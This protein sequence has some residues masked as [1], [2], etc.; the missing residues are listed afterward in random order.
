[1]IN[2]WVSIKTILAEISDTLPETFWN[3]DQII[4]WASK[5]LRAMRLVETY[6]MVPHF[7]TI[8][9]YKAK[10]PK[11]YVQMEQVALRKGCPTNLVSYDFDCLKEIN[12]ESDVQ[13][14]FKANNLINSNYYR[15][16]WVPMR[17]NRSGHFIMRHVSSEYREWT[18]RHYNGEHC[19]ECE[20]SWSID[21]HGCLISDL[22]EGVI[23]MIHYRWPLD[24]DGYFKIPDHETIREAIRAY[25]MK[26]H[27]ET[28]WNLKEEGSGERMQYYANKWSIARK[29]ANGAVKAVNIEVL[30]NIRQ[31]TNNLLPTS[32]RYYQF[33]GNLSAS[34]YTPNM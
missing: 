14:L 7:T 20:Y 26:R 1:M 25:V 8:R 9:D 17:L 28:R 2:N 4:E 10:L 33:F 29:A 13:T 31:M 6:E 19:P 12:T 27:W 24:E 18:E 22:K 16:Q 23:C 5:A 34:E 3:E 15:T 11:G 21:A 32:R 30:E